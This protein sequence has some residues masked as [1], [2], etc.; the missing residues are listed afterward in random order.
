MPI[1]F[2]S[3]LVKRVFGW[4]VIQKK[5]KNY[6]HRHLEIKKKKDPPPLAT[7]FSDKCQPLTASCLLNLLPR[8]IGWISTRW[9]ALCRCPRPDLHYCQPLPVRLLCCQRLRC[10]PPPMLTNVSTSCCNPFDANAITAMRTGKMWKSSTTKEILDHETSV[11]SAVARDTATA[12]R[13]DH[14]TIECDTTRESRHQ[15]HHS[16]SSSHAPFWIC[17]PLHLCLNFLRLYPI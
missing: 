14:G 9:T 7:L 16:S 10:L 3:E 8:A 11:V 17:L 6:R 12:Y 5:K 15:H 1:N 2:T 13:A 4:N